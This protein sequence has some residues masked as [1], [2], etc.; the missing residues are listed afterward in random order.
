M[1]NNGKNIATLLHLSALAQYFIPF[2]GFIFPIIIWSSAKNDSRYIDHHG[3][4][5]INFQ[6]SIFLYSLI[7]AL[8]AIPVLVMTV[9][10][11]VPF[12][13]FIDGNLNIGHDFSPSD[14][15]GIAI[16]AV[17]AIIVFGFLKVAE[18]FLIIYAAVKAADGVLYQYPLTINLIKPK[19]APAEVDPQPVINAEV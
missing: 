12:Q 10:K 11:N 7:L 1:E 4:Q 9:L 13:A 5:A 18:V 16:I 17:M 19:D 15:T 3:T 8:I 2:G 6:L 14:I